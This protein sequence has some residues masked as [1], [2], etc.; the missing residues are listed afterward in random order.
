MR[1]CSSR[2]SID[3]PFSSGDAGLELEPELELEL[4]PDGDIDRLL[5]STWSFRTSWAW[6]PQRQSGQDG[7][8][9]ERKHLKELNDNDQ[10]PI[11]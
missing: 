8:F 2:A 5:S 9:K 10:P 11:P 1:E 4:A 7:L 6:K 3:A